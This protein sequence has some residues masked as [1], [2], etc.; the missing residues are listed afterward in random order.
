M[1][2]FMYFRYLYVVNKEILLIL[3]IR[4]KYKFDCFKILIFDY[5]Y[6]F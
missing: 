3:K 1:Y 6:Y 2:V 5:I 4:I